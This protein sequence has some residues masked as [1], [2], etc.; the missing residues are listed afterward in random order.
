M[1]I[2][3]VVKKLLDASVLVLV[4]V[5]ILNHTTSHETILPEMAYVTSR[6][7]WNRILHIFVN[8]WTN[9]I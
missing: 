7:S 9:L 2:V 1:L 5:S 8:S 3:V 6:E 4:G